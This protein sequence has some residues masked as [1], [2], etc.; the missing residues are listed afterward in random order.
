MAKIIEIPNRRKEVESV[1]SRALKNRSKKTGIDYGRLYFGSPEEKATEN[2]IKE[3]RQRIQ[4]WQS[5]HMEG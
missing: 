3:K 4:S 5:W 1:Y 2:K